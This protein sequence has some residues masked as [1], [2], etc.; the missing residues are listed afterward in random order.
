MNSDPIGYLPYGLALALSV[1]IFLAPL[2][3]QYKDCSSR[4][5]RVALLFGGGAGIAFA[6]LGLVDVAWHAHLAH[7]P[8]YLLHKGKDVCSGAAFGLLLV[9]FISG[10]IMATNRRV[11]QLKKELADQ[12]PGNAAS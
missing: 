8:H 9:E 1:L 10:E 2:S 5:H 4:H 7:F 11:K 6:V 3:Y 12:R